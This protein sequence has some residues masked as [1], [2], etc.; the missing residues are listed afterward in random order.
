MKI[1]NLMKKQI[2]KNSFVDD[3]TISFVA[4]L[5]ILI[6]V[7]G[8]YFQQQWMLLLLVIDFL[9]SVINLSRSPLYY[10]SQ[11][12][13]HTLGFEKKMIYTAPKKLEALL[14][15]ILTLL[16]FVFF[17]KELGLEIALVLMILCSVEIVFNISIGNYIYK[18][19][20]IP[21]QNIL[22][23]IVKYNR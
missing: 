7:F 3:N 8:I 12:I 5:V 18:Y 10:V 15:L 20:M 13:T 16:I 14:G 2:N 4:Y 9:W 19:M 23:Q 21:A 22:N 17:D 11:K 6:T 1:G